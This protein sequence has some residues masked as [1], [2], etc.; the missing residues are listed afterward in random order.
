MI[1][2]INSE[3]RLVQT[4]FADHLQHELGW[5]NVYAW[6]QEDF[7]PN[8]LLGRADT[9]EVLLKRDLRQAQTALLE[10][11]LG[12]DYEVITA[13]DRLEKLADDFVKHASTRW[14]SGK[15]MLVCIDKITCARM[16]KLI[17]PRWKVKLTAI[18]KEVLAREAALTLPCDSETRRLLTDQKNQ[19]AAQAAWLESTI[20]ELII[21]EAQGEVAAFKEWRIN[22]IPHRA[23]H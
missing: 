10:K 6:N 13:D 7:G 4:T 1:T 21:S 17:M 19:F 2:D 11:L 9:R 18:K 12:K 16:H 8:S 23:I 15:S 5:E 20:I 14:E 22:I 3:D